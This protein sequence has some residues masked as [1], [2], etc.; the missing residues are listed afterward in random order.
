M[1]INRAEIRELYIQDPIKALDNIVEPIEELKFEIVNWITDYAARFGIK[2][3]VVGLSGGIDSSVIG[4]LV[5]DAFGK[6]NVYGLIMPSNSNPS[7]D[8]KHG[9]LIAETLGINY[10]TI[11]IENTITSARENSPGY[12]EG[13]TPNG[14]LKARFRM[15]LLY[16]KA[17]KVNGL[18]VGTDNKSENL[19]G[20][21]TKFGDGG[22][23]INPIEELYKTQVR[24]LAKHLG[25]SNEII[26]K[27]PSAGLYLNQ[28]D[29]GEMGMSYRD[30]DSI[31]FGKELG[32]SNN[33]IKKYARVSEQQIQKVERLVVKSEHKR[34][35][36][37][38][39]E[40]MQYV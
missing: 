21:F 4:H 1:K 35:L 13:N 19:T 2:N 12:F 27:Q 10:E 22:V 23:D 26:E 7:Q 20:Y 8:E 38:N 3:A 39:P 34:H 9:K 17:W 25:V 29:E 31:L 6:D 37:P 36:P 16:D 28:T 15:I 40:V 24:K 18:V 14:N 30:L 32:F 11:S 33:E 5:T